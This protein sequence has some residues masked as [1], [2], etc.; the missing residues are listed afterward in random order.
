LRGD[1]LGEQRPDG[2]VAVGGVVDEQPVV[3][4]CVGRRRH[5]AHD[6]KARLRR[7]ELGQ[8]GVDRKCERI[9]DQQQ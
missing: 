8:Q 5:A 1:I 6:R 2:P 3:A 7:C 4:R 9:G